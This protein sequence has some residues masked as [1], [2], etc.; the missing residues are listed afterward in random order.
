MRL[1]RNHY[2]DATEGSYGF[3]WFSS[4]AKA[5]SAWNRDKKLDPNLELDFAGPCRAEPIEVSPTRAGIIRA[6]NQFG[7]HADNG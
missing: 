5:V 1:Y 6:L 3:A 7:S 4:K 2:Y